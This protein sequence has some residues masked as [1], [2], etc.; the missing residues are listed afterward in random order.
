MR[1]KGFAA[2]K[3]L[4]LPACF[5]GAG[6]AAAED[7]SPVPA[8]AP[9]RPAAMLVIDASSSMGDKIGETAKL[10]AARAKLGEA[11]TQYSDRLAFGA[12]AFGHRK[13]SNCADSEILAKPGELGPDSFEKLLGERRQV[14][15]HPRGLD[16]LL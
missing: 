1:G 8:P 2:L 7:T 12:V 11:V 10:D 15:E 9:G 6:L 13:A 14:G 3:L 5:L 16:P 4:L